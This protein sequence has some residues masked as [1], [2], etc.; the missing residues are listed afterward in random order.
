MS[1]RS[2]HDL[3]RE[4]YYRMLDGSYVTTTEEVAELRRQL[5][6]FEDI[7]IRTMYDMLSLLGLQE[8]EIETTLTGR[9]REQN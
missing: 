6:G 8:D 9:H 2:Q 3:A 7:F 4:A 1:L 5:A